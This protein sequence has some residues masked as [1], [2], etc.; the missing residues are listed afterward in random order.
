ME[1]TISDTREFFNTEAGAEKWAKML[2]LL[3]LME[4]E[5]LRFAVKNSMQF[6]RDIFVGFIPGMKTM[7]HVNR[8]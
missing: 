8:V 1:Q 4:D 3:N 7:C 5:S 2:C 6:Y